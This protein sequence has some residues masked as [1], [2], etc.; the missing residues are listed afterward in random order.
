MWVRVG[1]GC[2]DRC[3][4]YMRYIFFIFLFFLVGDLLY[5]AFIYIYIK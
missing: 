1:V 4:A 3:E 2:R 5:L